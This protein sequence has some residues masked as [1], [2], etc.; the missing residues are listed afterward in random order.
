M[1]QVDVQVDVIERTFNV[2][3]NGQRVF[4]N[5]QGLLHPRDFRSL[6]MK[7]TLDILQLQGI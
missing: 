6:G 2:N 1:L 5:V 3:R 7:I 4:F